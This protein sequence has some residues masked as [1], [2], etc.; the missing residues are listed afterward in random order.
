MLTRVQFCYWLQGAIEIG[1]LS[2]IDQR[3]YELIISRLEQIDEH[4]P[5]TA[6][7]YFLL[8]TE[9]KDKV[10]PF[11]NQ[12]LQEVFLHVIDPSYEGDQAY[13]HALHQ[14]TANA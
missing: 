2:K 11:L 13:F 5:F 7:A 9:D 3:Q 12:K 14:G 4:G 10:F 6:A 1:G 8:K